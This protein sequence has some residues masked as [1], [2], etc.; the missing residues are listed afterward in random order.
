MRLLERLQEYDFDIEFLPG[1]QN[2]IQDMLSR[3]PDYKDPP[4]R[5]STITKRSGTIKKEACSDLGLDLFTLMTVD[6]DGWLQEVQAGYKEDAYFAEVLLPIGER[7]EN[8]NEVRRRKSRRQHYTISPDGL[9]THAKSGALCIP[10][11]GGL[12]QKLL[13]EAHDSAIGGHFGVQRTASA[14]T[15]RFFWPRL[16]QDVKQYVRGCASCHRAK[17]SNQ[18]P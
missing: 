11:A 6:A 16:Y 15:R 18:K 1:T 8:I 5:T 3:R 13:S 12:R 14:L 4:F 10:D 7:G 2:F 17:A 9:I